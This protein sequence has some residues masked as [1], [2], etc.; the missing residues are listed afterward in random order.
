M[1]N[2]MS[3]SEAGKIGAIK[4]KQLLKERKLK[5]IQIY[6]ESPNLCVYC[7]KPIPYMKRKNKCCCASHAVSYSNTQRIK[8]DPK[9]NSTHKLTKKCAI[10]GSIQHNCIDDYVCKKY[11]IFKTLKKFGFDTTKIGTS[12]II[13]EFYN[14]RNI[15]QDFYIKH[16][17]DTKLLNE[18]FNYT[19]GS[20]NFHKILKSLDIESRNFS[21]AQKFAMLHGRRELIPT[22]IHYKFKDEYHITWYGS[23]VYLRSSYETDYAKYL[24]SK[25]IFYEVETLRIKYFD[26]QEKTF[27]LAI[28]D[29]YI[30]ES[31]TIVEIK[32]KYTLDVQNMKDKVYEYKKL[33]YNFKLILEHKEVNI[34]DL[35]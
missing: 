4:T 1:R 26:S 35:N 16:G 21:D 32:S 34:Y 25:K 5:A 33:G 24:D 9:N 15:I 13:E 10:C 17:S 23:E 19:S 30:P 20:A 28:P 6:D 22:G 12:D 18:Y 14:I 11:R 8:K 7:G 3:E 31:N 27:R 29:F 2:G